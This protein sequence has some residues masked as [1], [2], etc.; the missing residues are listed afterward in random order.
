MA[1]QEKAFTRAPALAAVGTW[2]LAATSS[3]THLGCFSSLHTL[4][5]LRPRL[6]FRHAQL[7]CPLKVLP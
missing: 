4:F 1:G 3:A 2:R 6:D 5:D 7:E